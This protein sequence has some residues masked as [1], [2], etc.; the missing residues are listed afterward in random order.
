MEYAL[1]L[2]IASYVTELMARVMSHCLVFLEFHEIMERLMYEDRIKS[3]HTPF[4]F[5]LDK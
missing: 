1:E 3:C 2:T 4:R 5:V